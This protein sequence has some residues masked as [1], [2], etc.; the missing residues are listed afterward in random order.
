MER[1]NLE[2]EDSKDIVERLQAQVDR[3][4]DES[5]HKR[6]RIALWKSGKK[7]ILRDVLRKVSKW[8]GVFKQVGDVA[9][10]FDPVHAALPW[11]AVGF[12]LQVGRLRAREFMSTANLCSRLRSTT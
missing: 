8:L 4:I 3:A 6:W 2:N 12:L 7:I 1:L 10:Q 9:V 11:A 5:I